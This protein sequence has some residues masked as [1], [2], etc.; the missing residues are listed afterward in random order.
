MLSR[1]LRLV[2]LAAALVT[3]AAAV[4]GPVTYEPVC[5][6]PGRHCQALIAKR[7]GKI[8]AD[9]AL[10]IGDIP[11][12]TP[13]QLQKIYNIDPTAGSGMT[14]AVIDAY[15]YAALESDLAMYR[16]QFQLPA[17][18]V[19]SGCLQI[20]NL[21]G[22]STT[23]PTQTDDGWNVE[24]ALDVDMVSAACPLCK[25]I[26]VQ[27]NEPSDDLDNAQATAVRLGANAISNSW[28][29]DEGHDEPFEPVF[30]QT[31]VGIFAATGDNGYDAGPQYPA[32]SLHVI[33]VGGTHVQDNPVTQVSVQSAWSDAGSSCS[34]EFAAPSFQPAN[35]A[36]TMRAA[37]DISADADPAT[38][39]ALY[40]T[41]AGGFSTAGGTSAASPLMAALM[42]GANHPDI[43]PAFLYRH[44]DV[45]EDVLTG[46]N[47]DCNTTMCNAGSGWD[48]PTGL[49]TPD[50]AALI[51]IGSGAGP[52]VTID[53]PADGTSES[54]AFT[55]TATVA[56]GA[57]HVDLTIDGVRIGGIAAAP[58]TFD[59][60][61]IKKA[62]AHTIT[63]SAYD[64]DHD[65]G[66]ASITIHTGT[67]AIDAGIG[68]DAGTSSGDNGGCGCASHGADRGSL[69][70]ILGTAVLVLRRRRRA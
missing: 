65:T 13:A 52:A 43:T 18:T 37:S 49:G 48:G 68:G 60:P 31:G 2:V 25:I 58:Y 36:C 45:I 24:T 26:V 8:V 41:A 14:V 57:A 5:H 39:V 55:V 12:H 69:F 30:D 16:A 1:H 59:A 67:L 15:G 17:C 19:A 38:G 40:C 63:V 22:S 6:G 3:P 11:S 53:S 64:D 21:D 20:V 32:T 28:S 44:A 54:D 61:Q 46:A 70:V 9:V 34:T 42:A 66:S 7:D 27:V 29:S 10:P 4:A 47:G 35:A 51:A 50:Q 62:G 33:A 56:A 23:L